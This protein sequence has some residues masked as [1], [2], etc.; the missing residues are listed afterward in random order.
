MAQVDRIEI[1]LD[2]DETP[3]QVLEAPPFDLRLK[4]DALADGDHKARVVTRLS[5]GRVVVRNLPFRV[6]NVPHLTIQGIE[7][8]AVVRGDVDLSIRLG[9]AEPGPP[10]ASFWAY[11]VPAV[12]VLGAVWAFFAL[13][14]PPVGPSAAASTAPDGGA[15][16][17]GGPGSDA[18]VPSALMAQGKSLYQTHCATCHQKDGQGVPGAFPPLAGN[19]NL[20]SAKLVV[21][22]IHSGHSG[23]IT[24]NGK[25]FDSTMPAI[26]AGFGSKQLAA[27]ATFVRNAWGNAYGPVS[28]KQASDILSSAASSSE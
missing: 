23:S 2:D 28:E 22:T 11:F 10:K 19:A 15:A 14:A 21:T 6:D 13:V 7:E 20:S 3:V 1:F 4:T 5:D 27:V 17:D 8:N 25:S 18:A 9:G 26:G 24:V 12:V 16:A